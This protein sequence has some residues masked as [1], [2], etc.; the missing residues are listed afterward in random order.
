ML[1]KEVVSRDFA[2]SDFKIRFENK[3]NLI[4][5]NGGNA[6]YSLRETI[7]MFSNE[8]R[9]YFY[10]KDEKLRGY[11]LHLLSGPVTNRVEDYPD[12]DQLQ[13]ELAYLEEIFTRSLS[14]ES[15]IEYEWRHSWRYPWGQILLM[16]QI[17]DSSITTNISW[18]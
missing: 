15:V 11:A 10:F 9:V 7:E 16:E 8:F 3:C 13:K 1:N 5:G 17:Q 4:Y 12:G 6:E 2:H 14:G 18:C